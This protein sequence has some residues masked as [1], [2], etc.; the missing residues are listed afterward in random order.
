MTEAIKLT[1]VSTVTRLQF[2]YVVFI[3][4]YLGYNHNSFLLMSLPLMTLLCNQIHLFFS[5][6]IHEN[7]LVVISIGS[8]PD[9]THA[10][11]V[12]IAPS[13]DRHY[14]FPKRASI[15]AFPYR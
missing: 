8:T 6:Y 1:P 15:R 5:A 9:T 14:I 2:F 10:A 3:S 7:S 11:N 12:K 13:E 4:P